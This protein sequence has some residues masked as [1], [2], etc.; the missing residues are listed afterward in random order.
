[1]KTTLILSIVLFFGI[2]C[3]QAQVSFKPGLRGGLNIS[4]IT[5]VESDFNTDFYIGA[6]GALRLGKLY[7]LQPE[8]TYTNQGGKNIEVSSGFWN[9][10]ENPSRKETISI[11]YLSLGLTNKLHFNKRFSF[12]IGPTIDFQLEN[13]IYTNTDLDFGF[14]TGLYFRI[15]E[16][17]ELEGRLKAGVL[18][19]F[20]SDYSTSNSPHVHSYNTNLLF[21]LGLSYTFNTQH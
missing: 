6:F 11:S 17:L 12:L 14:T 10:F 20:E 4:K 18:D 5:Q 9:D 3:L 1:M 21:Q 15:L 19:V 16:N 7:T 2:Q 13:N 8:I